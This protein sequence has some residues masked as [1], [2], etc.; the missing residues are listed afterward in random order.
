MKKKYFT[1]EE[2]KAAKRETINRW[3]EKHPMY[4]EV[5]RVN[6]PMRRAA[7][8]RI[9]SHNQ[10]DKKYDRGEG[11]L[12][13]EWYIENILL[14][15]CVYCG[16]TDWHKLGCNRKDNSKPHTIDNVECCCR[17]CNYKLGN[18]NSKSKPID[19]IDPTT[20]EV[21]ASYPS[22]REAARVLGVNQGN[23]SACARGEKPTA[24]GYIWKYPL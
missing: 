2:R 13:V 14:K 21:L 9:H 11:N 6:N 16:E 20:G 15:S 7:L 19:Q 12:T 3:K 17:R 10:M 5:W 18:K 8:D 23:I 1:E 4:N 24:Y 22:A